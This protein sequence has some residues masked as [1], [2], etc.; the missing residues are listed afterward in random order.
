M[1][2]AAKMNTNGGFTQQKLSAVS[3]TQD[4]DNVNT[5]LVEIQ[6]EITR[7][8][9]N[10][11]QSQKVSSS[12]PP[13]PTASQ[14]INRS[15]STHS[16]SPQTIL[17]V[18]TIPPT[19]NNEQEII[20]SSLTLNTKQQQIESD[21]AKNKMNAFFISFGDNTTP[22][23][24]KPQ[25]SEKKNL[26]V[27]NNEKLIIN[28]KYNYNGKVATPS[29]M[30]EQDYAD[31]EAN[32]SSLLHENEELEKRKE[33]MMQRQ[34]RRR[35]QLELARL[36]R[37]EERLR[38]AEE[39]RLKDEEYN[40]KKQLEKTRKDA[41]YRAYLD[42]KKQMQDEVGGMLGRPLPK[43]QHHRVKSSSSQQRLLTTAANAMPIVNDLND[44]DYVNIASERS[45]HISKSKCLNFISSSDCFYYDLSLLLCMCE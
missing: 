42:K 2:E 40:I 8:Q 27:L 34:I 14:V 36:K 24:E 13:L 17:K 15:H 35:E 5:K 26:V 39:Q 28:N 31:I 7:L 19:L 1:I 3:L 12:P 23:K 33:L 11:R 32:N 29:N 16:T 9:T 41:I 22:I 18:T 10:T 4:I 6:S 45:S 43:P 38:L 44:L 21:E 20:K 30:L 37:D 25:L